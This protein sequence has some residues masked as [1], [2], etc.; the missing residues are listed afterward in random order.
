MN[1]PSNNN[2]LVVRSDDKPSS[3]N[4]G[5]VL[6]ALPYVEALDPNY[7]NY[8]ISLIEEE[9]HHVLANQQIG[10]HPSLNR[11]STS[12]SSCRRWGLVCGLVANSWRVGTR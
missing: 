10:D 4:S 8:A 7:E 11:L 3:S 6:D 12:G 9:M 1:N 2:A 5:V